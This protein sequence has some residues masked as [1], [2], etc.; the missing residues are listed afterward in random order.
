M[1]ALRERQKRNFLATMLLS[2][3]VPMISH[4]DELGRTQHG[5]NNVYCQDNALSWVDWEQ[6]RNQD[7]LTGFVRRLTQL[8]AEH[9]IFRRRR[10]FTGD[11]VGDTK[12]PDI[13]WLRRDGEPMTGDDWNAQS[14]MTMTVFL[15]GHGLPER[16]ALG[17]A[18]TDASFLLLFNPLGD[19]VTFTL[20]PRD[21]G[22]TWE[23][24]VNTAD[25][26]LATRRK[27]ARAGGVVEVG[28][29]TLVV[30][31]CRY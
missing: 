19:Q 31:R 15:N 21:F 28:G 22:R 11:L 26:L 27:T 18:I 4:G 13:A 5:N 16:D 24:V 17:E 12:V 30:L 7:V 29:H 14:G 23:V 3:G 9:P 2:Q 8:R 10:F 25:P 6:A 20:P 1:V